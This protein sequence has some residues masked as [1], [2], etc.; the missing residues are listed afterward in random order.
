MYLRKLILRDFR[1]LEHFEWSIAA[2]EEAGWHV[3]LGPNGCGKSSVLKAIAL[4]LGA[5]RE[6]FA[7]RI[8]V[9]Q[10][11]RQRSITSSTT[12]E[13]GVSWL[14]KWDQW[15]GPTP[16]SAA[17]Q[18]LVPIKLTLSS[19]TPSGSF[20]S[21]GKAADRTVW[22]GKRGWFSASFGPM[23]RFSG[24]SN[25]SMQLY[26]TSP[27]L[28]RHLSIFGEDVALSESL[29][30]L[31]SMH[32]RSLEVAR[33]DKRAVDADSHFA[34]GYAD[35]GSPWLLDAIRRF[36][37]QPGFLP[38]GVRLDAVSSE[39]VGFVDG[40]GASLSILDLSDGYRAVLS[41]VLELFR[42]I[43]EC[44][45]NSAYHGKAP[46]RRTL[47]SR[48]GT[49]MVAPGL[50][51]IDEVDAH[52]HP[53][54]QRTIGKMLVSMFPNIQFLVTTHSSH[55]AQGAGKGSVWVMPEPG[56]DRVPRRLL[57][58]DLTRVLYG[59]V[60]HALSGAAFGGV[61]GRSDEA[62]HM[63]DRVAALNQLK[64]A[65]KLTAARGKELQALKKTL[66]AVLLPSE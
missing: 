35:D 64:S 30:W 28:A 49:A 46:F 13:L 33:M 65:K 24:G 38:Y 32:H 50:V 56:N 52:L 15:M 60:L 7:L 18:A 62:N 4:A 8:P 47:M 11:V 61:P 5:G 29:E 57:G 14:P 21:D 37:N 9:E 43:T 42:L 58:E 45:E 23:R 6:F 40:N 19:S 66:S 59:D 51:L 55:V 16:K 20:T 10:F 12:I 31:K 44:Y 26:K 63:L 34:A 22:S 25:S 17:M 2:G 54:W 41:L 48:D 53:E 1:S 36:V 39:K 3:L 27:R